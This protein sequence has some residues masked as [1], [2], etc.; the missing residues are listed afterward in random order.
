MI[1]VLVSVYKRY[2][3]RSSANESLCDPGPVFISNLQNMISIALSILFLAGY[4]LIALEHRYDLHKALPAAA[5]GSFLWIIIAIFEGVEGVSEGIGEMGSEIFSLVTFLLAA[6]TLVEILAHYRF[7]DLI[8]TKIVSLGYGIRKQLWVM[9]FVAFFLSALLDNLTTTLVMIAI[10]MNF[11]K[12]SD[13]KRAAVII[14]VAANAGGAWSP[15]GDVTTI[16]LWLAEKFTATEIIV[17]G[18]L[19]SLSLFLVSTFLLTRGVS[20]DKSEVIE[21]SRDVNLSRSEKIVVGV[22]LVSFLFPIFVSQIG[23]EPYIGLIFGLGL[24]GMLIALFK[25]RTKKRLGPE[26]LSNNA[27][28]CEDGNHS[29]LPVLDGKLHTHLTSNIE[30]KL[31]KIDMASLIFFTGIL[32]AVGALAH[33]GVLAY[34][35]ELLL[36]AT[37]SMLRLVIG[38]SLLGIFSA[39]FDNIPLTAAAID[40]IQTSDFHVWILLAVAVGTGGSLL[41][42]GSAAG[43]VAMGKVRELT[44]FAYAKMA[45]VP[46]LIGYIV[47]IGAWYLQ[48]LIFA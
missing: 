45:T 40:I 12:G 20:T 25:I 14:V 13:L 3:I 41:V 9:G 42:I 31:A 7:F 6:M 22:T 37:P 24:A 44:F 36:G 33:V 4:I 32:L 39:I 29:G 8:K 35:S 19:P 34:L 28:E 38:S 15:I 17:W 21:T 2:K 18:F 5:V 48:Y 23:L 16:I 27:D 46:V 10:S 26:L 47:A 30:H 11:F 43:V 1:R